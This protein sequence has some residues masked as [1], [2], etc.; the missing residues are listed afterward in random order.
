[1]KA[2]TENKYLFILMYL[3]KV[4]TLPLLN[5]S[6]LIIFSSMLSVVRSYIRYILISPLSK[7]VWLPT[8]VMRC[9]RVY[10]GFKFLFAFNY[11]CLVTCFIS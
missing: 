6:K 2:K 8:V 9:K 3:T 10:R 11:V 1:M 5:D 4:P 7:S